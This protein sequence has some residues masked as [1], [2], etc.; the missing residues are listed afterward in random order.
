MIHEAVEE[1]EQR[2]SLLERYY[3]QGFQFLRVN[4]G[5]EHAQIR[6]ASKWFYT[7]SIFPCKTF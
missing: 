3:L 7:K 5:K 2:F 4:S 1:K 6:I